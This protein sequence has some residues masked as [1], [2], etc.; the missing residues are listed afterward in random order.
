MQI[1][2]PFTK[3][4]LSTAD[5]LNSAYRD[6]SKTIIS[7]FPSAM[8]GKITI[9]R[10]FA[11]IKGKTLHSLTVVSPPEARDTYTSI[12]S[13]GL[14]LMGKTIFPMGKTTLDRNRPFYP[15]VFKVKFTNLPYVCS[16]S[17]VKS[18]LALPE[19]IKHNPYV[20]RMK[21][22]IDDDVIYNGYAFLNV[23]ADD[24]KQEEL[25]RNWSYEKK[26][27]NYI[28]WHGIQIS[29][30]IPSI[31]K[32][33]FCEDNKKP[34]LGHHKDWC[35]HFE[36]HERQRLKVASETTSSASTEFNAP[37]PN[38]PSNSTPDDESITNITDTLEN[39]EKQQQ[40]ADSNTASLNTEA[41]TDIVCEGSIEEII[42][43]ESLDFPSANNKQPQE[44][45]AP[46]T[47]LAR[48]AAVKSL[49]SFHARNESDEKENH[50]LQTCP[51]FPSTCRIH[52]NNCACPKTV[53]NQ[54][55]NGTKP[56]PSE[57][58][59]RS[60][61]P[62]KKKKQNLEKIQKRFTDRDDPS[63]SQ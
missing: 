62:W 7:K 54:N 47:E 51:T 45:N 57:Y 44:N 18:L 11:N 22:K 55:S 53:K 46:V 34:N 60:N 35:F 30:H 40:L 21:V 49:F 15:K 1:I 17:E 32:C 5:N 23:I 59:S 20:N 37:A 19:G 24:E 50:P 16:D 12:R 31:H 52:Q 26:M 48:D 33:S 27:T 29:C 58:L 6:C 2:P 56:K 38:P 9:S 36:K 3:T 28:E 10:T 8:R 25:L 4:T 63:N 14:V 42:A 39:L 61:N 43:E 41:K 13:S